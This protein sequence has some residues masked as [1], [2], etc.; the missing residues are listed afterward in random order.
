MPRRQQRRSATLGPGLAFLKEQMGALRR[1]AWWAPKSRLVRKSPGAWSS[2]VASVTIALDG[3]KRKGDAGAL[4]DKGDG[5]RGQKP[6][7]SASRK[8]DAPLAGTRG[9]LKPQL[10][11]SLEANLCGELNA[12]WTAA[13]QERVAD[14]HIASCRDRES[15]GM[16]PGGRVRG[17][18]VRDERRHGG[19]RQIRMIEHVEEVGANLQGCSFRESGVLEDAEVK[20]L[21]TGTTQT[22]A[23]ERAEMP[24]T[25]DAISLV[26]AAIV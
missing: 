4:V 24:R 23:A 14:A 19:V 16:L 8:K 7:A 15:T 3:V 2:I 11:R 5:G 13:S 25:G 18:D 12:A 26:R 17:S 20:F 10:G 6:S 1:Q 9:A 22:V 21:E